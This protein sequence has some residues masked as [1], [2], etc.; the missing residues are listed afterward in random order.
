M[1]PVCGE[2]QFFVNH[3]NVPF[4]QENKPPMRVTKIFLKLFISFPKTCPRSLSEAR[5][6]VQNHWTLTPSGTEL[7]L[8]LGS[9]WP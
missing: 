7:A 1:T 4:F 2:I 5:R 6:T 9:Y 3:R 8:K